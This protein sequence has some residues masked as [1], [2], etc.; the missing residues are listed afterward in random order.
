VALTGGHAV[1]NA[2]E[3]NKFKVVDILA[4]VQSIAVDLTTMARNVIDTLRSPN[5][6]VDNHAP[7]AM[8]KSPKRARYE[9]VTLA[10]SARNSPLETT[11]L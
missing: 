8:P 3:D 11:Q 6:N 7:R 5:K 4:F 10:T 1:G 2:A 9:K